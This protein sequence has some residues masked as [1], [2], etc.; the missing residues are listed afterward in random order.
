MSPGESEKL[1]SRNF[2]FCSNEEAPCPLLVVRL[3]VSHFTL[4][5]SSWLFQSEI[6]KGPQRQTLERW[7]EGSLAGIGDKPHSIRRPGSAFGFAM[8]PWESYCR[9]CCILQSLNWKSCVPSL[10]CIDRS[11]LEKYVGAIQGV[12]IIIWQSSVSFWGQTD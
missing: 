10:A 2:S 5:P 7:A 11:F 8:W 4:L 1:G 12:M 3:W 9:L 6:L